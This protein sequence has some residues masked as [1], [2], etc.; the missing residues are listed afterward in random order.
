MNA[1]ATE[2]VVRLGGPLEG[3]SDVLLIMRAGTPD[4]EFSSN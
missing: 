1:L 3:T 4:L 2:G